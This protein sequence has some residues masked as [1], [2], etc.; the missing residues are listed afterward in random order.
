MSSVPCRRRG[1]RDNAEGFW[2]MGWPDP[3]ALPGR[4]RTKIPRRSVS[5]FGPFAP[6][7][8]QAVAVATD[9]LRIPV[10]V[11]RTKEIERVTR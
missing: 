10:A 1:C 7:M 9:R 5:M 2:R 3:P 11:E 4:R 8:K 6:T